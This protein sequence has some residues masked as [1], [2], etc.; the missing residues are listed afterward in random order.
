MEIRDL[1]PCDNC[2][3]PIRPAF[4]V[5]DVSQALIH[6]KNIQNL[7]GMSMMMD[8][9]T[10]LAEMFIPDT[11]GAIVMGDEEPELKTRIILC[12]N[13]YMGGPDFDGKIWLP[14]LVEKAQEMIEARIAHFGK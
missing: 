13:C 3:G 5:L 1:R 9:H 12:Q 6:G 8:G 7:M 10:A 14:A 11:T 2:G 4:Y